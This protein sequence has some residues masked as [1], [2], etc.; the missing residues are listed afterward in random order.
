MRAEDGIQAERPLL[1]LAIPTYNRAPLL[2]DLLNSLID[3]VRAEPRVELLISDNASSDET[4]QIVEQELQRGT[5]LTYLRNSENIGPDANF[6][7]CF[8]RARGKY[9]WV[10]GDDDLLRPGTV[11]QVLKQLAEDDYDL[12]YIASS[13]FFEAP[14]SLQA[15]GDGR[16]RVFTEAFDFVRHVHIFLTLISANIVNKDTISA[17]NHRPFSG[18]VNSNLIQLG[19]T[20]TALRGHRKSLVFE[21]EMLLYRL[22]NTGGY[23]I[24][25]VFGVT[26]SRL[27]EEWLGIPRLNKVVINASL[28]RL[29]PPCLLAANKKAHGKYF[30]EDPHMLLVGLFGGSFR[31]RF[32]DYPLIVLPYWLAWPWLQMVRVINR[33]DRAFG[34][35]SLGW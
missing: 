10:V 31:Y 21:E 23:G 18:L 22:A 33:I 20:F 8:E 16:P 15:V 29:M 11:R 25:K 13:G 2:R 7:Q 19:W 9:F 35:V 14:P 4:P 24:C 12:A 27:T 3:Q 34:F 6:L 28:Q 30:E 5:V 26:L 32:F 17:V 1:T